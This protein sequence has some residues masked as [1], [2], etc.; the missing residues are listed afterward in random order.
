VEHYHTELKD[1][2]EQLGLAA[3]DVSFLDFIN[4]NQGLA[5]NIKLHDA[6][7]WTDQQREFLRSALQEDG[8]WAELI[9]QLDALLRA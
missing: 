3:D 7:F 5:A 2:F 9:D 4:K 8:E 6:S 1:L